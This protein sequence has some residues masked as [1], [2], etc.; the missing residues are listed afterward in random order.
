MDRLTE[1]N[2]CFQLHFLSRDCSLIKISTLFYRQKDKFKYLPN[3]RYIKKID[4][5]GVAGY[6]CRASGVC[7]TQRN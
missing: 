7:R 4:N 3:I 1:Q 2:K 6:K 5:A